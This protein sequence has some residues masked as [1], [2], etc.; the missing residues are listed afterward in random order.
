MAEASH[1]IH[2]TKD[3][4]DTNGL[5]IVDRGIQTIKRDLAAEVGKKK[6]VYWG[7]VAKKVA[8]DHNDKPQRAVFGPPDS[9]E[10]NPVQEFKVLQQNAEN[11]AV[12]AKNTKRQTE[13][14][15]KAGFFREPID[16]GGRSFKPRYG[17]AQPV[18]RV[19]SDYVYSKGHLAS[20]KRGESGYDT[21][22]LL[23]QARPATQG[24]LQGKLTLDTD[25]IHSRPQAKT[26]LK[27]QAQAL[28][29]VLL[30]EGSISTADLQK[31]VP[32][33]RRFTRKYRNLT[34]TNWISKAY[35]NKFTIQDGTVRLKNAPSSSSAA[36]APLVVAPPPPPAAV[37]KPAPKPK[38]TPAERF[39]AMRQIY[40]PKPVN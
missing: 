36:P 31:K 8:E 28:E 13:A 18:E 24:Q 15:Q 23:K 40:G 12:D 29:N 4:R 34:D 9:V 16:N 32:G 3:V 22:T 38:L 39:K 7:D 37:P 33:L 20:I 19:Q 6:G 27:N 11:Y 35:G 17:P 1:N 10:K 21:S 2:Q 5:A 14:I 25:K 30:K 26:V